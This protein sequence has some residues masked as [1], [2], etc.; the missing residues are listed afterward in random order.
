MK[1]L[2][3]SSKWLVV[4]MPLLLL[5]CS[6]QNEELDQWMKDVR[7]ELRPIDTSVAE[8]KVYEP[9]I[10][11]EKGEIHPFDVAKVDNALSKLAAR[12][13]SPLTPNPDRRRDPL[14]AFPLDTIA[15]VG[16]LERPNMR[17]ALLRVG[18]ILYQVRVGNYVGQNYGIISQITESEVTLKEV[19]QDA[20]GEWVER[21]S[22]L[23][24]QEKK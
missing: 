8:P 3:R 19:V 22:T 7:A 17:S 21:I 11:A 18:G 20:T 24:L 6:N 13:K 10:Y 14:E 9:F 5:G 12:S 2:M 16:L 1:P 4:L 15:M 23:Q